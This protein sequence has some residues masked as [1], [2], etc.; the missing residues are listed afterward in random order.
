MPIV[1]SDLCPLFFCHLSQAKHKPWINLTGQFIHHLSLHLVCRMLLEKKN[2]TQ[3]QLVA[4]EDDF[5]PNWTLKSAQMGPTAFPW[6]HFSFWLLTV[7]ISI[8]HLLLLWACSLDVST[9][10][11]FEVFCFPYFTLEER[12]G[13]REGVVE[14]RYRCSQ[15]DPRI[16]AQVLCE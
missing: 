9:N 5:D 1:L 13:H 14:P 12:V 11:T 8:L 15:C 16:R 10:K 3:R 4:V 2:D 7:V 6:S